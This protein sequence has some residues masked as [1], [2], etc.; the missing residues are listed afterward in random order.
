V[1]FGATGMVGSAVLEQCLADPA[2]ERVV[3]LGRR[4]CGV[5]H[6][7]LRE[8]LHSDFFDYG[9]V[10][11][12]LRGLNA[13]FFTLGISSVGRKEPEY[14]RDTYDLMLAAAQAL[15]SVNPGM[16]FCYVSGSGTDS[17]GQGRV[18]WARV[19]GRTE[20]ALMALPFAH[21]GMIRLAG[22]R[23]GKGFKSKT[24]WIRLSY[25]LL[26]P[27]IPLF[28]L[29]G[30]GMVL[31]GATLGRAMIRAAQGKAGK[32]VLEPADLAAL[33]AA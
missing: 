20:N 32:K 18:M 16:S 27:L 28:K 5:S 14:T 2:V 31:D 13:C 8:V 25:A 17:T 24:P 29:L 1:L 6:P 30:P 11:D 33:G 23:P 26:R 15:L 12:R 19:K 7:K 9:P 10:L 4:P 21:V 22:L 3:A